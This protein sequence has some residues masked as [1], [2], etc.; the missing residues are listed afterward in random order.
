MIRKNRKYQVSKEEIE[1]IYWGMGLSLSKVSKKLKIPLTTIARYMEEYGIKRRPP[2]HANDGKNLSKKTR[3]KLSQKLSGREIS[4]EWRQK[5]SDTKKRKYA[6]GEIKVWS[7]GLTKET[8]KALRKLGRKVSATKRRQCPRVPKICLVCGED[9]TVKP[10]R[11]NT[12]K[13]CSSECMYT[14]SRGRKQSEDWLQ[15]RI[16]SVVR[17]LQRRPTKPEKRFMQIVKDNDLPYVYNGNHGNLII[18]GKVPDF[19]HSQEDSLIEIFGRAFH[20]P[21][22][23]SPFPKRTLEETVKHYTLHGYKCTVLWEDELDDIENIV[24]KVM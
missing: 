2:S 22:H 3:Q 8:S 10:S 21:N 24:R 12:A 11:E 18:G 23:P 14:A 5:I 9:F 13:Y 17:G 4:E 15:K 6:N 7:E 16:R 1:K 19:Y 20:D